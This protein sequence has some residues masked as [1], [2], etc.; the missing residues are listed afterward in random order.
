MLD[1]AERLRHALRGGELGAM[2]LAV[3]NREGVAGEPLPPRECQHG[4]GIE[5]A[6]EQNDSVWHFL[7]A[8]FGIGDLGLEGTTHAR[9]T[10]SISNP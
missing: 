7:K 9:P 5:A 10:P 1:G 3:V 4:G 6:G 2:T 8:G